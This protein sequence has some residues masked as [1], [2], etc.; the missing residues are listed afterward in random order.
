LAIQIPNIDISKLQNTQNATTPSEKTDVQATLFDGIFS[1]F[2]ESINRQKDIENKSKNIL[3][4]T[5]NNYNRAK[6]AYERN[7]ETPV[8]QKTEQTDTDK[9]QEPEKD[10]IKE[11]ET[12]STKENENTSEVSAA[13]EETVSNDIFYDAIPK[14]AIDVS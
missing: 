3:S 8:Q 10:L 1:K 6:Q 12:E 7:K 13:E 11:S 2:Q 9:S 4:S 5:E 14:T